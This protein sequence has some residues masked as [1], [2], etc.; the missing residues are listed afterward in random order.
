MNT[1]KYSVRISCG[2]VAILVLG[3]LS[4]ANDKGKAKSIS[5]E[6]AHQLIVQQNQIANQLQQQEA[7]I[8]DE[9]R[10]QL[11]SD[12]GAITAQINT[13]RIVKKNQMPKLLEQKKQIESQ[14]NTLDKKKK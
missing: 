3:A 2:V 6:E 9:K 12:L 11:M 8:K 13:A 5:N 14:L 7:F 4:S 1:L 10:K